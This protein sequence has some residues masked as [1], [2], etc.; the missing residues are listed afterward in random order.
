MVG[1]GRRRPD[2]QTARHICTQLLSVARVNLFIDRRLHATASL[3]YNCT[4]DWRHK[5]KLCQLWRTLL[6]GII[7]WWRNLDIVVDTKTFQEAKLTQALPPGNLE[8]KRVGAEGDGGWVRIGQQMEWE[9]VT[10]M[11]LKKKGKL[12][13][14]NVWHTYSHWTFSSIGQ[15]L[16]SSVQSQTVSSRLGRQG[17]LLCYIYTLDSIYIFCILY[18]T[19]YTISSEEKSMLAPEAIWYTEVQT[20]GGRAKLKKVGNCSSWKV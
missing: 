8:E 17:T 7:S 13:F 3:P 9:L 19:R 1:V 18:N 6:Y 4:M 2:S 20:D 5:I 12:N 11:K 16:S 14:C 10:K 15:S